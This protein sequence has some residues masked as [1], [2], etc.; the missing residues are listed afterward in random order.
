MMQS[1]LV[2]GGYGFFGSRI[3]AALSKDSSVH[4][5]IEGRDGAKVR[6]AAQS[7]GLNGDAAIEI[8]S[9]DV[10]FSK[11]LRQLGVNT[12]VHTAGPLQNQDCTVA[13]AATDTVAPHMR[14]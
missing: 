5:L 6:L 12:I 1:M 4:V 10:D 9:A 2:L 11:R 13:R 14:R 3:C 8:N 7:L